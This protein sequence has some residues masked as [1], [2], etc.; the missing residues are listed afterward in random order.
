MSGRLQDVIL[1]GT[2]GAQP[3]ATAVPAGTLYFVT[4]EGVTERSDASAWASYSG[5]GVAGGATILVSTTTLNNADIKALPTT[6]ITVVAAPAAGFAISPLMATLYSKTSAG[7]YTNINAAAELSVRFSAPGQGLGYIVNDAAIANGSATLLSDLLGTVT[8]KRSTLI[9]EQTTENAD[10]WGPLPFV[11][12]VAEFN[13]I[14]LK[15]KIDNQGSGNLT[16]GNVANTLKVI[17][18]YTIEPV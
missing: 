17:V 10:N 5:A 15:I 7:A 6:G 18:Y 1:R 12:D 4:D 9:P 11:I 8:N 16:G 3:V 2:R 14:A 13:G